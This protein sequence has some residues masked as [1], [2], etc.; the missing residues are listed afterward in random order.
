LSHGN[1]QA[2][3]DEVV[4]SRAKHE[5]VA[6]AAAAAAAAADAASFFCATFFF[7]LKS[8]QDFS[9]MTST[10]ASLET[11]Q[12]STTLYQQPIIAFRAFFCLRPAASALFS[13]KVPCT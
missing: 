7:V 6:A 9:T 11:N 10:K 1:C 4:A 13:A 8:A 2:L 12:Q 3:L 5:K